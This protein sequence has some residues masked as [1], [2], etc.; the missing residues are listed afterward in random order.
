MISHSDVYKFD[1][2]MHLQDPDGALKEPQTFPGREAIT[3]VQTPSQSLP[4]AVLWF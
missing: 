4:Q 2:D 1:G 3:I